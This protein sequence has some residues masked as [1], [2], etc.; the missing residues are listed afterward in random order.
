MGSHIRCALPGDFVDARLRMSRQHVVVVR[1]HP[2]GLLNWVPGPLHETHRRARWLGHRSVGE[3]QP[4]ALLVVVEV[5][6]VREDETS[7]HERL[8]PDRPKI[9]R[10]SY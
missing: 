6:T 8:M 9:C 2:Q 4:R 5:L 7:G 3:R 1:P 10:P